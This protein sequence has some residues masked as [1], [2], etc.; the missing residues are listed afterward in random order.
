MISCYLIR[1]T[2]SDLLAQTFD[3]SFSV[4]EYSIYIFSY[5]SSFQ[6]FLPMQVWASNLR[7]R[8]AQKAEVV[9]KKTECDV[10]SD[11]MNYTTYVRPKNMQAL[12]LIYALDAG[13][14]PVA[15][16]FGAWCAT[17]RCFASIV[18]AVW[19]MNVFAFVFL[20]YSNSDFLA[21]LFSQNASV[22]V[23]TLLPHDDN[24]D[25]A[26]GSSKTRKDD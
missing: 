23:H 8:C 13:E 6:L 24:Y 3:Q 22:F 16:L 2:R 15:T 9:R 17:A 25:T 20:F 10:L 12:L 21:A 14:L 7:M 18:G 4:S 26:V 5:F 11:R 1:A 19:S